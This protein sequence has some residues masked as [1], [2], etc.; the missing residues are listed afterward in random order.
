MQC[1][2]GRLTAG[3]PPTHPPQIEQLKQA[4]AEGDTRRPRRPRMLVL[5][6]TKELVEQL[7]KVGG[8]PAGGC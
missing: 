1:T 6:P 2:S 7:T 3:A 5:G 8:G 4:E